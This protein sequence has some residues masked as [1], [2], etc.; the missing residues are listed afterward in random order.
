MSS[1]DHLVAYEM[2]RLSKIKENNAHLE[3]LGLKERLIPKKALA[4][5]R[6]R[7]R[8]VVQESTRSLRSATMQPMITDAFGTAIADGVPADTTE[9][10]VAAAPADNAS[11][12]KQRVSEI[13]K[14]DMP[15]LTT[16]PSWWM[17]GKNH[18]GNIGLQVSQ[19]PRELI[20]ALDAHIKSLETGQVDM[21]TDQRMYRGV[22]FQ[23][24]QSSIKLDFQVQKFI[25]PDLKRLGNTDETLMG[26]IMIALCGI[27]DRLDNVDSMYSF[28][29]YMAAHG[30]PAFLKW[31][32]EVGSRLTTLSKLKKLPTSTR[33][34]TLTERRVAYAQSLT[35][36]SVLLRKE[37]LAK[38][39]SAG[40]E[41]ARLLPGPEQ[42]K[43]TLPCAWLPPLYIK[44]VG[45]GQLLSMPSLLHAASN[46]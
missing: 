23:P 39:A 22:S 19:L 27:D 20:D 24:S 6:P 41:R 21:S 18:I 31:K 32:G 38:I 40:I 1:T 29:F 37:K 36:N 15:S 13:I 8:R 3:A 46:A 34:D 5:P 4:D 33:R 30:S 16:L 25:S 12:F 7:K 11:A 45:D 10:P 43:N 2:M 35:D 44:V 42:A 9:V 14:P 28:L 17:A 26:A